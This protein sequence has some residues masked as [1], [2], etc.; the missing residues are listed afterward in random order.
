VLVH[1]APDQKLQQRHALVVVNEAPIGSEVLEVTGA[2]ELQYW[3]FVE[4][5]L[6]A[7]GGDLRSAIVQAHSEHTA[8]GTVFVLPGGTYQWVGSFFE[9]R[10]FTTWLM[11]GTTIY[12]DEG[13]AASGA[14]FIFLKLIAS[15]PDSIVFKGGRLQHLN[16][17]TSF[18]SQAIELE[19]AKNCVIEDCWAEC[20]LVP[21]AT[22]GRIRWG[23]ALL[24]GD[25]SLGQGIGNRLSRCSL[26]FAQIQGCAQGHS[27]RNLLIEGTRVYDS[28]DNAISVV[29]GTGQTIENVTIR[30]TQIFNAAGSAGV[31]VGTDGVGTG[32]GVDLLRNVTIDGVQLAG[33]RST[34][35]LDFPFTICVHVAGGIDTENV[36]IAN[37]CTKLAPNSTLQAR[38]VQ[39]SSQDDEV[40]WFGLSITNAD[41]GVVT[42]NDPLEA[43]FVAGRNIKGC[44][45]S[46]VWVRGKRG[47]RILNTD[48]LT[49]TNV[50]TIDGSLNVW[51]PDRSLTGINISN[52]NFRRT[53]TFDNA[54]FFFANN[55]SMSDVSLSNVSM[56]SNG[57]ALNTALGGGTMQMSLSNIDAPV[58]NPTAETLAG[59]LRWKNVRGFIVPLTKTVAVPALAAGIVDYVDVNLAGTRMSDV[60]VNEVVVANPTADLAVAAG[61]GGGYLYPRVKSAG[62]VRLAFVGP[63]SAANVDF[64]FDRTA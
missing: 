31:F 23:F 18:F 42:D 24:G 57:I 44:Q 58:A 29:S 61:A 55:H 41:L 34:P 3:V 7:N 48:D 28:N 51:A 60:A 56:T 14:K 49:L 10:N 47:V 11:Y 64:N 21:A 63:L 52:S 37:I 30:D 46:N 8:P 50:N 59:I 40:S 20:T 54:I 43:L 4:L 32:I 26:S 13:G 36:Q 5:Y 19:G 17:L 39:C 25:L 38:S 16:V 1:A 22:Q 27:V 2:N 62:V 53:T 9:P 33:Q 35:D 12:I 45:I 15:Q 6:A